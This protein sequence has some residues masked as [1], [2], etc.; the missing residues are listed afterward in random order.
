VTL[1]ATP[2]TDWE[3]TFTPELIDQVPPGEVARVNATIT[4][5]GD[6][7]AGDY[8]VTITANV[9][10]AN[11]EIELRT[12]VKTSGLWGIIGLLLIVAALGGLG[13]VFRTYG[14]R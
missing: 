1:S 8:I 4:P 5:S 12:T 3:V 10:E 11:S 13:Y 2:P 6:S 9:P 14:R 7:V